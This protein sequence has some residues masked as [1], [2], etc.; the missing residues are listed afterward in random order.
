MKFLCE[1]C[2][3]KYQIADDRVRGKTVRMKCRKCGY[4]IEIHASLVDQP[5]GETSGSP[6]RAVGR[7]VEKNLSALDMPPAASG[8]LAGAFEQS[9]E[10][11]ATTAS[12]P[13]GQ[14]RAG[15]GSGDWYVAI[16]GVPVGPIKVS[17]LRRKAATGAV[18]EESLCWQEGLEEW[19]VLKTVSELAALVREAA[20]DP[21]PSLVAPSRRPV[22]S[23]HSPS[24]IPAQ[25]GDSTSDRAARSNVLSLR[26]G[27]ADD[28]SAGRGSPLAT[29]PAASPS[30][31]PAATAPAEPTTALLF[32]PHARRRPALS[33]AT[34]PAAEAE[35]AA[36]PSPAAETSSP[37]RPAAHKS[38]TTGPPLWFW[39]ILIGSLGFGGVAAY[40]IFQ[41]AS[42]SSQS[43]PA[44]SAP[45]QPLA[46][47]SSEAEHSPEPG[48]AIEPVVVAA[49]PPGAKGGPSNRATT[50]T[51]NAPPSTERKTADLSDLLGSANGPATT[52]N[53]YA[54]PGAGGGLDST[55]I[56][57]VVHDRAAGVRRTCWERGGGDQKSSANVQVS[58]TVAPSGS[59]QSA[60]ATGDDPVI[61]KCI[62]NAV[63]TWTFPAPGNTTTINIPFHFVRQ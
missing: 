6:A 39:P 52:P 57:R 58:V 11:H 44:R 24:R 37:V 19:R 35:P 43:D 46:Q 27:S 54:G 26:P 41:P 45:S 50:A 48:P 61:G 34:A 15:I 38:A 20:H 42:V 29:T 21:R 16:N 5:P 32:E 3:A 13:P 23:P 63:K 22:P 33:V 12:A 62:E 18:T 59:V 55:T 30:A 36:P 31:G 1:S 60:T 40:F 7:G 51:S 14:R 47:H 17:E 25:P 9:L 4:A 28:S 56:Q 2:K 8:A 53:S 49:A 10:A